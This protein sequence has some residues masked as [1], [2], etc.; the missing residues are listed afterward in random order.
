[1]TMGRSLKIAA[2]LAT[3]AVAIG[4]R[5]FNV[6]TPAAFIEL[7][8]QRD[9][10]YDFRATTADGVVVAVQGLPNKQRG[11]LPFWSEAVRNKLRDARGY[12]LLEETDVRARGGMPGKQMRFGRD[13]A[14]HT[15]RYWVTIFVRHE[16][17][18]PRVWVIEA[19]G[20]QEVFEGR[21]EEIEELIASFE[22]R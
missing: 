12:A 1:M 9:H 19:G 16:G 13:E 17:R 11:T 15:F 4:C 7:E 8:D 10:D 5:P 18:S 21:R 3:C 2:L 14:G 22:P 6:D 20:E